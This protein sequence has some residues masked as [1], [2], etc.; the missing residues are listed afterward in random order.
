MSWSF[1]GKGAPAQVVAGLAEQREQASVGRTAQE[2]II[3]A[4]AAQLVSAAAG[5]APHDVEFEAAGHT[6]AASSYVTVRVQRAPEAST[7]TTGVPVDRG[8]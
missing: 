1:R 4:A 6:D 3:I 2:V 5:P 7:P 8:A